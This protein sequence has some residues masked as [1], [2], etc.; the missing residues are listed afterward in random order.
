MSKLYKFQ[1]EDAILFKD[2]V[3]IVE[4]TS[5]EQHVFWENYFYKSKY[6]TLIIKDWLQ[7]T[8]GKIITIGKCDKRPVCVTI[9]WAWLDG[10]KIMFYEAT[11]QVVDHKMVK[12]WFKH[13][14]SHIKWD[15]NT[16]LAHCNSLNFHL[17]IQAVKERGEN[18][19][20]QV[21]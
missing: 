11:S 19:N 9:F 14:S 3:F 7:E 12:E 13:F 20:V 4:A 1:K 18:E 15:G 6:E 5:Y 17:C 21:L 8:A 10:C 2:V 16:R